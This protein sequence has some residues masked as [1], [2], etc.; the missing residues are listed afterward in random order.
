M[1]NKLIIFIIIFLSV[2]AAGVFVFYLNDFVLQKP[3]S[4]PTPSG[5]S[6]NELSNLIKVNEPVSDQTVKSPLLVTGEARGYWFFEA[7]FPVRIYD[8]NGLELGVAVAQAQGDPATG[9]VNWMTENF[10]PFRAV[11]EFKKPA[12][13]KGTLVL[14]KDNPSG[15]PEHD[16]ELKVPVIFDLDNW[17]DG[18]AI[19][20]DCRVTGCSGQICS[21]EDIITTCEYK[22]E[23]A[24]YRT[25]KCERQNPPAGGGKCGWTPTEE[26]VVCLGAAFQA[27]EI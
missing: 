7:S 9:E 26:L 4:T 27:E 10:V 3:V 18:P 24:C 15:L 6:A 2:V 21:D 1:P 20:K 19:S 5:A 13:R 23:Y 17:T 14:Q 25:T 11:L 12:T 8:D 22:A 16:A